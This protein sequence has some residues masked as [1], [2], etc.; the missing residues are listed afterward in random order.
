[1]RIT[2]GIH[3]SRVLRAPR[4][5]ATRPTSDRVRE[6]LFGILGS[7]GAVEGARVLDLY[8]G[9]GALAFEALSRGA[10]HAVLVESSP[11]ALSVVRANVL[12]LG[13]GERVRVIFGDA[14]NLA[15][16]LAG[17]G[18]FDLLLADPPWALV[19][20]GV[21]PR[22]LSRVVRAGALRAAA[23]VVLEHASRTPPPELDGLGRTETRRYGDTALTFYKPAILAA[24]RADG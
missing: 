22:A 24:P 19:D 12:A 21:A 1:M 6:A 2:G 23:C 16:L 8:A 18:P 9:S 17:R 10:A 14:S 20:E 7:A 4:G 5:I 13:L 15:R 11:E 3:R